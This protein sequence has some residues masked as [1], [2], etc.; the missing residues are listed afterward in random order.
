MPAQENRLQTGNETV[1]F[2]HGLWMH[3]TVML[4]LARL[5][6]RAGFRT[7]VFSYH[8][9][10]QTPAQ[11]ADRL[12]ARL[13][14][15]DTPVI[16]LVG[17][18]LG[19][20]VLLHL[21]D[22]HPQLKPGRVVLL[23]SPVGGS[24]VAASLARF[25]VLGALLLGRSVTNGLLG[26]APRFAGHRELGLICGERAFGLGRLIC[27]DTQPGDGTVY[28]SETRV[29]HSADEIHV[30][31]THTSMLFSR[32]VAEQI[33]SFLQAGHFRR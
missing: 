20:I 11:A 25:P 8:S 4:R 13:E 6:G 1:V 2:V 26:N 31:E 30:P 16:H 18:S 3:G 33:I 7:R 5:V 9:L 29:R 15:I 19:G 32:V 12:A 27:R 28:L 10:L 23:G 22:R 14:K 24:R 21:L 17:H